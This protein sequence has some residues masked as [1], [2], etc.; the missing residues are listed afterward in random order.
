[1]PTLFLPLLT[2]LARSLHRVNRWTC[3]SSA[4]DALSMCMLL[5]M[6]CTPLVGQSMHLSPCSGLASALALVLGLQH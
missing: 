1:M 4:V 2:F 5:R 6:V 3:D